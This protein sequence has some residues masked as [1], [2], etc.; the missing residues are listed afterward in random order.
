MLRGI[1]EFQ[2]F[3]LPNPGEDRQLFEPKLIGYAL[4]KLSKCGGMYAK[5]LKRWNKVIQTN[6][7]NGPF[8]TNT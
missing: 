4:I 7:K 1:E 6:R 5:S 2:I 3:L 8:S